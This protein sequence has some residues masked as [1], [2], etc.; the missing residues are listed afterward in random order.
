GWPFL[1]LEYVDGGS[2]DRR[3]AGTPLP[4]REAAH[5][6]EVLARAVQAAHQRG[7]VHRDLKPSNILLRRKCAT[8][9]P[10]VATEDSVTASQGGWQTADF[11]PKVTDFGLAKRLH[12]DTGQTRSGEILGTPSYMAPEQ[13]AG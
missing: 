1:V 9:T 8:P 6:V 10:P 12:E 3:I 13:A 11:E 5:L 7:I 4:P 2:L